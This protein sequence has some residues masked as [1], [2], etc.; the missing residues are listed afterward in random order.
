MPGI[1]FCKLTRELCRYSGELNRKPYCCKAK[2]L[3]KEMGNCPKKAT[4]SP[5]PLP[6][7][8]AGDK[9]AIK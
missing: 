7:E 9:E 8:G 6:S 4:P 2:M 1:T 5:N 3:I